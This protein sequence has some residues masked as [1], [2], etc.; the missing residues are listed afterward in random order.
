MGNAELFDLREAIPK[1]Q[2]SECL[3]YWNQGIVYCTCGHL[4]RENKSCRRIHRLQWDILSIPNYVIKEERLH[5]NRHGKLK[6][7]KEHFLALNLRKMY[8]NGFWRNSRS[9][10][11][12]FK[13]LWLATQNWSDWSNMHPDRRGG[14]EKF[15]YHLSSREYEGCRRSGLSLNTSGANAP[16]KLRSDFS[17]ASTKMHRLHC[18]SGEERLALIPFWQYQK[19][20]SSYS[21]SSASWWHWNEHWWSS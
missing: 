9:L 2:C 5:G 18:E 8:Q 13:F 12:R 4:L 1:V 11:E 15:T 7:K 20:H 3:H 10:S 16:M 19:W 21:S 6:H 17:E 14:A